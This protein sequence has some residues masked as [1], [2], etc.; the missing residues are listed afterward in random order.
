[1]TDDKD[2]D[3]FFGYLDHLADKMV[4]CDEVAVLTP[5]KIDQLM[6]YVKNMDPRPQGVTVDGVFESPR[7]KKNR[8]KRRSRKRR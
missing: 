5:E 2:L 1:M 6:D 3:D 7:T 4:V 8:A